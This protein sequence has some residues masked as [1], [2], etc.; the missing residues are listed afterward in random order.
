MC[1]V[2]TFL[3]LKNVLFIL[4]QRRKR[5]A[6]LKRYK[7]L[8]NEL[9]PLKYIF[10]SYFSNPN[11]SRILPN[12]GQLFN[13]AIVHLRHVDEYFLSPWWWSRS[14]EQ[15]CLVLLLSLAHSWTVN[16]L[17]F[18]D[19]ETPHLLSLTCVFHTNFPKQ[20]KNNVYTYQWYRQTGETSV[21]RLVSRPDNPQVCRW[22][23]RQQGCGGWATYTASNCSFIFDDSLDS[24]TPLCETRAR[25]ASRTIGWH[26]R[27]IC[28]C[29]GQHTISIFIGLLSGRLARQSLLVKSP[30]SLALGQPFIWICRHAITV[31][32]VR[33]GT[34]QH[35]NTL[36]RGWNSFLTRQKPP[37][38][39]HLSSLASLLSSFPPSPIRFLLLTVWP[40]HAK[41]FH[42]SRLL[43]YLIIYQVPIR[44]GHRENQ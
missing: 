4:E 31:V 1:K 9:I 30:E 17:R 29:H 42:L 27:A 37:H 25:S 10:S 22:T 19:P 11:L 26:W 24:H 12:F 5:N 13:D 14:P 8:L 3:L 43:R 28:R 36:W 21:I 33:W 23:E 39:R 35:Q 41:L 18:T 16:S 15:Q 7:C 6:Y 38:K 20:T 44:R 34:T 32:Y 2:K 40:V